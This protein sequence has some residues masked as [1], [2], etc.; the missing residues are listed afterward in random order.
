MLGTP[1]DEQ[2]R[3]VHFAA[4]VGC[5]VVSVGYRL[6]PENPFPAA[7]DDCY[8]SLCWVAE[9][10]DNL[11]IDLNRIAVGG[12][13]RSVE[14]PPDPDGNEPARLVWRQVPGPCPALSASTSGRQYNPVLP[15]LLR[16]SP[17]NGRT[18]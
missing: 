2:Q 14:L 9:H 8:R 4:K 3:C 10:G 18:R 6:A 16:A 12:I 11:G 1:D 13:K 15:R 7:L 5:I 17:A